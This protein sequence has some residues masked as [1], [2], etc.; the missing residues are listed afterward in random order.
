MSESLLP[1]KDALSCLR[2]FLATE[3]PLK[4]LFISL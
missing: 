2:Q 3:N 1:L 4:V